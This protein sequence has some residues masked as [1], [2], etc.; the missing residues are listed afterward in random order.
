[1]EKLAQSLTFDAGRF[2]GMECF[3]SGDVDWI[4][5]SW[6]DF[7][8]DRRELLDRVNKGEEPEG[9]REWAE[10]VGS[11]REKVGEI[12]Y[13]GLL[14]ATG[15]PN[16]VAVG[17]LPRGSRA[18]V[19]GLVDGDRVI[20]Y[21]GVRIHDPEALSILVQEKNF[22]TYVDIEIRHSDG[23]MEVISIVPGP[24]GVRLRRMDVTPCLEQ[25]DGDIGKSARRGGRAGAARKS[26]AERK[27]RQEAE[28]QAEAKA[29]AQAEA[30]A[31]AK[32][33][34]EADALAEGYQ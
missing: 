5:G 21:N 9:E 18:Q 4:Q 26:R 19:A 31:K 12:G 10:M 13:S 27:A 6:E 22:A 1:M 16:G 29:K 8:E 15:Q 32:A 30:E 20:H 33:Q 28:A 11:L 7:D 14:Y 25:E 2:D 24:L 17:N 23:S 3:S 34:A